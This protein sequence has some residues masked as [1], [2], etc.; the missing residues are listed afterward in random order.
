MLRLLLIALA[1]ALLALPALLARARI[2]HNL[3][4]E[5]VALRWPHD[6]FRARRLLFHQKKQLA[7]RKARK[8]GALSINQPIKC[9]TLFV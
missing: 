8:M 6:W 2:W 5:R 3:V 7:H 1:F 4:R 9:H